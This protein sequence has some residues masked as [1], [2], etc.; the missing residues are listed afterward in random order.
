MNCRWQRDSNGYLHIFDH[1]RFSYDTANIARYRPTSGTQ[2]DGHQTGSGKYNQYLKIIVADIS[3]YKCSSCFLAGAFFE[4]L[5]LGI[6]W[7]LC[8]C[9]LNVLSARCRSFEGQSIIKLVDGHLPI[10]CA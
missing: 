7:C 3:R 10:S 5:G 1:A 2:N 4:I 6:A 8:A 9:L